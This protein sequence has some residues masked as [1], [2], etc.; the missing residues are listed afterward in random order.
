MMK[1]IKYC[2]DFTKQDFNKDIV[3]NQ[4]IMKITKILKD[5]LN[6]AF[7]IMFMLKVML[8]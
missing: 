8:K 7:A 2:T 6:F 5:F 1:E 3:I 4:K